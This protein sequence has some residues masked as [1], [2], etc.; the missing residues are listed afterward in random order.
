MYDV[1]LRIMVHAPMPASTVGAKFNSPD[2]AVRMTPEEMRLRQL[3][4]LR[5]VAPQLLNFPCAF[6][7][8]A[9]PETVPPGF[10]VEFWRSLSWPIVG[11]V[12]WWI[13]GRGIDALLAARSGVLSPAITWAETA[14][15]LL[16]TLFAGMCCVS[17]FVD[18]TIASE[19]MFP[20]H[21]EYIAFPAWILLGSA[22]VFARIVQWRIRR[23]LNAAPTE[24]VVA[25]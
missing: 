19:S 2:S 25:S 14:V 18:D 4:H 21:A 1:E 6:V 16:L 5:L 15:A 3:S 8:L 12:F 23:R 10:I 9:R 17:F 11:I 13:V 7:G 24:Q 20:W 22:T